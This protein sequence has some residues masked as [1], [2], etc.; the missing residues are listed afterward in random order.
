M[1]IIISKSGKKAERINQSRFDKEDTLQQYIYEN[2][3][4]IPIY[5][6]KDDVRTLI[7]AREYQTSSGPIDAL[8]IDTDG[9]IYI[10]ETK[11]YKNTD[12]RRVI[13]QAVDY[14]ASLW[15]ND[16]DWEEF[17][18]KIEQATRKQFNQSLFERIQDELGLDIA[19][20]QQLWDSVRLNFDSSNFK[21]VILMDSLD[22][23][24]KDLISYFNEN[25]QFD[26]YA[27]ELDYYKYDDL[28]IVIPKLFGA[29]AKKK[30]VSTSKAPISTDDDFLSAYKN[31]KTIKEYL[32]LYND[33]LNGKIV[34]PDVIAKRTPKFMMFNI[35]QH[36]GRKVSVQLCID[37][38]YEG[39]GP[40]FWVDRD[41]ADITRKIIK[42]IIPKAELLPPR[43]VSNYKLAKWKWGD[44]DITILQNVIKDIAE[45]IEQDDANS[46]S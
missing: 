32:E 11:L 41:V 2:P 44:V 26:I 37:P 1:A 28:E 19:D 46:K 42:S 34:I 7:I 31:S 35:G 3:S 24:L 40:Q 33:I 20:A 36:Q 27:V 25:S 17:T 15:K 39:G 8:A 18:N 6:I 13:T 21:F 14:G 43:D 12:K 45:G 5:D 9:D 22:D 38:E 4:V 10:I 30:V 16:N 23:R 29:E